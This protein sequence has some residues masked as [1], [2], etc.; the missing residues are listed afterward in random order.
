M[1]N[2]LLSAKGA[3]VAALTLFSVALGSCATVQTFGSGSA[4]TSAD[5]ILT[6]NGLDYLHNG[7]PLSGYLENEVYVRVSG[8]SLAGWGPGVQPYFNPFHTAL[9]PATQAFYF[10]DGGSYEWTSIQTSDSKSIYALEFL[11]GNGWTTGD[12]YGVPWGNSNAYLDWRTLK[13]G[14]VVSSGTVGPDPQLAVGTVLGFYDGNGFD[15][16]Q[17]RCMISTSADPNLQALALDDLKIQTT[18][19]PEPATIGLGLSIMV[20]LA[21]SR[22]RP[23]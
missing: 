6:F 1:K 16:L 13:G 3:S 17:L 10:P 14:N 18:A 23:V 20:L 19:V 5:R 22:R 12:I 8:D 11:Y 4:V 15:E 7:T 2:A 21:R 9:D